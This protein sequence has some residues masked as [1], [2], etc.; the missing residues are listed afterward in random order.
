VTIIE[1]SRKSHANLVRLALEYSFAQHLDQSFG[2]T[3][4]R[5]WSAANG[6]Q[7]L[8]VRID[9]TEFDIGRPN[10]NREDFLDER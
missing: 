9:A 4:I 3:R 10:I 1:L 5:R 2:R 6:L 8:S 7:H